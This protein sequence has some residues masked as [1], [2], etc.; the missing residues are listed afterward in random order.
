VCKP[1]SLSGEC[2]SR[3]N[4]W[5]ENML[6][7]RAHLRRGEG[8]N[9]VRGHS[10]KTSDQK[11]TFWTTPSPLVQLRPF[12]ETPP[13]C[14][15]V[16]IIS[17]VTVRNAKILRANMILQLSVDRG[18]GWGGVGVSLPK[19]CY[20]PKYFASVD[21]LFLSDPSTSPTAIVHIFHPPP[22]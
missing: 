3:L 1:V 20:G 6:L 17:R 9:C 16:R 15:E 13:S 12:Q 4:E 8:Q 14:H 22:I 21:V 5:V 19:I 10:S 11:L 2:Q 7:F 18:V